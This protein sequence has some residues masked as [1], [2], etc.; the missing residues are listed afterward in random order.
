MGPDPALPRVL[1]I[2]DDRELADLLREFLEQQGLRLETA[3]DGRRGLAKA[4]SGG[5][6][7]ILLDVMMPGLDGFELL[8]QVRRRSEVPVIMLTARTAKDDR[9]AGLGSGADDYVPKPFDPDELLA[10][11]RAV[12]RRARRAPAAAESIEA[13]GIRLV[14]TAR[15]ARVDGA[16]VA[17]T[18][19]EYDIL[20]TLVRAAGR[21]VTRQE[22]TAILYRRPAS[23]FDRALDV[24]VGRLRKKLGDLGERVMTVRG[25]GFL[26]RVGPADEA[27]R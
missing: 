20:E 23:P 27:P 18:P 13:G 3:H 25:V 26:Y 10:R 15:E 14:P 12:L 8:R 21:I 4:L 6:D 2:D 7:L 19:I 11:I 1:L 5:F 22:L 9:L 24:H 17:Q 16:Q